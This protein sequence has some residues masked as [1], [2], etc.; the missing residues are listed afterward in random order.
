MR[1]KS[2]SAHLYN[3][4]SV[5][6]KKD[7]GLKENYKK[8]LTAEMAIYH[9]SNENYLQKQRL[10]RRSFMPPIVPAHDA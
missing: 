8:A 9:L 5:S 1:D 2:Q 4:H 7:G 3:L 6:I 10:Q